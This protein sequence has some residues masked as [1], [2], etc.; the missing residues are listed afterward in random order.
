MKGNEADQGGG[1]WGGKNESLMRA[2]ILPF[3]AID[4]L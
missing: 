3:Y 2:P 4:F 1:G